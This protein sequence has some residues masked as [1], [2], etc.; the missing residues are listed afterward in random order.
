METAV[1]EEKPQAVF[2]PPLAKPSG[3]RAVPT[4]PA[5]IDN[6]YSRNIP[7]L[8][9][10][11]LT[12][13]PSRQPQ[14]VGRRRR[15]FTAIPV[16]PQEGA[17]ICSVPQAAADPDFTSHV[18]TGDRR[19]RSARSPFP[20]V[21]ALA[22]AYFSI[23]P[24]AQAQFDLERQTANIAQQI[25]ELTRLVGRY[26][27]IANQYIQID[28]GSQGMRPPA[29]ATPATG[30]PVLC[31]SLNMLGA[32]EASYRDL[33][34]VPAQLQ[35]AAG[36]PVDF[37]RDEIDAARTVTL[38][39]VRAGYAGQPGELAEAA[40][41]TW[42]DRRDDAQ[43]RLAL[44]HVRTEAE[45]ALLDTAASARQAVDAARAANAVTDTGVGQVRVA[46]TLTAGRLLVAIAQIKAAQAAG[47]AAL[48]YDAE[49]A[50][51]ERDAMHVAER[52]ANAAAL[53]AQLQA[54]EAQREARERG[55]RFR[56]HPLYGGTD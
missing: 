23:A 3:F 5:A 25:Q 16:T 51:R 32:F 31:D 43:T 45:G 24:A 19:S 35:P 40:A 12:G 13:G 14:Q 41:E 44:A 56:L 29:Q 54:I 20:A 10:Q 33:L 53:E 30:I 42:R 9:R 6:D 2:P 50:R 38:D 11:H 48:E 18:V 15:L 4:G 55:L 26:T 1:A 39:D 7:M 22:L 34:A 8:T 47:A 37:W 49:I 52:L 46:G 27:A 21:I 17:P 36:Q 28:C